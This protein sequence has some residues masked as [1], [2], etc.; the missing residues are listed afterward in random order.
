MWL[1][2]FGERGLL[3]VNGDFISI[4]DLSDVTAAGD[5]AVITGAFVGDQVAGAVTRYEDFQG[6]HLRKDY[7]PASGVLEYEAGFISEQSSS[8]WARDLVAEAT[9]TSPLGRNWDYGFII[10]NTEFNRLEVIGVGGNNRWFHDTWDFGDDE[11]TEV[12]GGRLSAGLRSKNHLILMAI[13]EIGLGAF[14]SMAN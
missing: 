9:L 5:V 11:Y 4:L 3:F 2:A 10:R 8:V 14:L 7:G 12:A 6:S 13:E 1:A